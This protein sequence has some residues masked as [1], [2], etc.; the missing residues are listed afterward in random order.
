MT[1]HNKQHATQSTSLI[2]ST[3]TAS[4]PLI[5][6]INNC[7]PG[8]AILVVGTSQQN[9]SPLTMSDEEYIAVNSSSSEA[10]EADRDTTVVL[11]T[12]WDCPKMKNKQTTTTD[13]GKTIEC[14][15]CGHCNLP[16]RGGNATKALAHVL[17]KKGYSIGGCTGK[18]P[19]DAKTRYTDLFLRNNLV[20]ESRQRKKQA[21]ANTIDNLHARTADTMRGAVD[22]VGNL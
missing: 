6:N 19:D 14:W 2:S 15:V 12:I 22:A 10:E 16:F 17:S 21:L 5:V 7:S 18:I 4:P 9:I 11:N 13:D 3:T 20:S 1:K 8:V